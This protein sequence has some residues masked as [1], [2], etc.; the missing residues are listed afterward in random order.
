MVQFLLTNEGTLISEE[1]HNVARFLRYSIRERGKTA[2][3]PPTCGVLLEF[4][5]GEPDRHYPTNRK[6]CSTAAAGALP[7][8]STAS[9]QTTERSFPSADRGPTADWQVS[10]ATCDKLPFQQPSP[11]GKISNL[12]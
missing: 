11:N 3:E 8:R 2:I 1:S 6:S 5:V 9:F 7:N 4:K 10:S 12:F